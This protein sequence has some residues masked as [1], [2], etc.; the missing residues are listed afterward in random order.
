MCAESK[1]ERTRLRGDLCA[2]WANL[3]VLFIIASSQKPFRLSGAHRST[4]RFVTWAFER[5]RAC[6]AVYCTLYMCIV[7]G[8]C[9]DTTNRER[10]AQSKKMAKQRSITVYE[11]YIAIVWLYTQHILTHN[12][13]ILTRSL[14]HGA[15]VHSQAFFVCV[16]CVNTF[17][18]RLS[19]RLVQYGDSTAIVCGAFFINHFFW[20]EK[21]KT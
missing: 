19:R 1:Q 3:S 6:V 10:E 2:C 8:M 18:L 11:C 5:E 15:S 4:S 17:Q 14:S 7:F 21:K 9:I 20:T 13:H 16:L 12:T